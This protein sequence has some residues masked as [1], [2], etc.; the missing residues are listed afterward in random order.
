MPKS[1]E[2]VTSS[3]GPGYV[4]RHPHVISRPPSSPPAKR[5]RQTAHWIL[6][7]KAMSSNDAD[8]PARKQIDGSPAGGPNSAKSAAPRRAVEE[9]VAAVAREV[10][11]VPELGFGDQEKRWRDAVEGAGSSHIDAVKEEDADLVAE[12][13][14]SRIRR[15]TG[16]RPGPGRA[17]TDGDRSQSSDRGGVERTPSRHGHRPA[18]GS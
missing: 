13:C 2:T 17:A 9:V 18:C 14:P 8:R 5:A 10:V 7:K 11:Q 12:G 1:V 3:T 16:L 6:V 15:A 4:R